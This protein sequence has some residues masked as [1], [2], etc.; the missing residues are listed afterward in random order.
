MI[1][2][3]QDEEES[4]KALP[5]KGKKDRKK[6]KE[7]ELE[8]TRKELEVLAAGD[9]DLAHEKGDLKVLILAI[10]H[11][12]ATCLCRGSSKQEKGSQEEEKQI[13]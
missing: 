7:A 5:K 2:S 4:V 13:F 10:C 9:D 11:F 12:N 3:D 1:P 6:I 8:E